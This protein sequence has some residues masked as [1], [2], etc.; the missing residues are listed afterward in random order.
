MMR[1]SS[2]RVFAAAQP[3]EWMWTAAAFGMGAVLLLPVQLAVGLI[4]TA[5][6]TLSLLIAPQ[7]GFTLVLAL[8]PLRTL[9]STEAPGLLPVDIGLLTVA[10]L[11]SLYAAPRIAGDTRMLRWDASPVLL[12]V[13]LFTGTLSLTVF[14]A[15]SEGAWLSEWLKWLVMAVLVLLILNEG[16]W[17]WLLFALSIAGLSHALLGLYTFLGGSGALHLLINERFFRAFG[18]F[19]QPNPFGGFMGLLAPLML[20][21]SGGYARLSC[22]R[23]Q[24]SGRVDAASFIALYYAAVAALAALGVMISWSR[25][26]WLGF[27][28]ALFVVVIALPRRWWHSLLLALLLLSGVAGMWSLGL[29]PQSI[30]DRIASATQE[31]FVSADVR[32][33]DI[34]PEN[35]AVVERLAHWQAALNMSSAYPWLG[36]GSG[37]YEVAYP[38][39]RL[40]NWPEPLGHAH[41]YYLNVL[42]EAGIMG[43]LIYLTL[44]FGVLWLTWRSRQHPDPLARLTA[45]GLL[46]TWTYLMMHS[47]TDQLYVNNM[48]LHLGV[49]LG[50]TAVLHKQ[51]WS[52]SRL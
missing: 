40:M 22:K 29:V 1:M 26:A 38:V 32:G 25:G 51:T 27:A 12:L 8:S 36:V 37:N 49:M 35:Y 42:G 15:W 43:L 5:G 44:W 52:L 13:L 21:V 33:V 46:G 41:N 18:S 39:F 23:W 6:L 4:V 9:I 31:L 50:I 19:G 11:L 45:I 16:R 24:R 7:A 3:F 47:L 10:V 30:A 14:S 20:S 2:R 34:T 17:Q 48:F 28:A